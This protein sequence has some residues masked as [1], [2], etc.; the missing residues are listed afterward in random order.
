MGFIEAKVNREILKHAVSQQITCPVTG[1]ILDYRTVVLV[2]S[3][4]N[5]RTLAVL[6]PEGWRLRK[7]ALLEA[8]PDLRIT[9]APSD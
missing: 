3:G 9:N 8:M 5:G 1:S 7:D 4:K 2:E 6:S